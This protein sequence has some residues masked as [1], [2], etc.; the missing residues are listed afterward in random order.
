M[1]LE[2]ET[3]FYHK[4]DELDYWFEHRIVRVHTKYKNKGKEDIVMY[5]SLIEEFVNT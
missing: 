5:S 2:R 1:E 4:M 3:D